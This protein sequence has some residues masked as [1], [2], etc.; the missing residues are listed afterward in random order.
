VNPGSEYSSDSG[1]VEAVGG[2][3]W[4]ICAGL[5]REAVRKRGK[6][7]CRVQ[8]VGEGGRRGEPGEVGERWWCEWVG[9]VGEAG[10][11]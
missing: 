11:R 3:R 5:Q 7:E 8:K 2:E 10:K 6:S 1:V 9:V 4:Y